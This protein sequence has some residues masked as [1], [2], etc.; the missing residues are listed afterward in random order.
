MQALEL[1]VKPAEE[2]EVPVQVPGFSWEDNLR[3]DKQADA[4]RDY[5]EAH[6]KDT[7]KE[8]NLALVSLEHKNTLLTVDDPRLPVGLRSGPHMLILIDM[9][10][11]S[12]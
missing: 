4:Y 5:L 6:L 12:D 3:D 11:H 2:P 9:A 7:L 10:T 1:S 8:C